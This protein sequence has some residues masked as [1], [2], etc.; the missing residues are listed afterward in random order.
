MIPRRCL[1][2]AWL[3]PGRVFLPSERSIGAGESESILRRLPGPA[4]FAVAGHGS[5]RP[6]LHPTQPRLVK[7][8][9]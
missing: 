1:R 6:A 5:T 4:G 3:T 9:V 8:P 2:P 7:Y